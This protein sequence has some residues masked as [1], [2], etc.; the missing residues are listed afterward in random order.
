MNGEVVLKPGVTVAPLCL[1][2]VYGQWGEWRGGVEARCYS[3]SIV[4][5]SG[6]W[7]VG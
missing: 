4:F 1:V 2:V 7:T 5:G 6:V 3:G